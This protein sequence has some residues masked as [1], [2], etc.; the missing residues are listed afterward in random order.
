MKRKLAVD[1][2]NTIWDLVSPW[3]EYYNHK[4]ND[5]IQYSDIIKYDF[6][7]ITK[8]ATKEEMFNII[9][10]DNF[11]AFINPYKY[12]KKYLEK[13]NNEFELYIVTSTSYKTSYK[14]FERFFSLFPFLKEDQLIITSHKNLLNIDIIVDDYISHLSND[15]HMKFL[16]DQPYNKDVND[17][18]IIRV[19]NLKDVYYYLTDKKLIEKEEMPMITIYTTETCPKCKIL[20]KKLNTKS[21]N[22]K[23]IN[24]I[25]ILKS[26]DIYEVPILE[27]NDK[28]L[29]FSEANNWINNQ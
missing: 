6:F 24:D 28:Y 27:V 5:D 16:I 13:L 26:L 18:S 14:K 9:S 8:K 1:I 10:S 7:D 17:K 4:F 12:S 25:E 2:D 22:Y 15:N 19:N 23:E 20:K 11:W 29:N 21:I 3:I